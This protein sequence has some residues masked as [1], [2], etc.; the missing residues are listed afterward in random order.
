MPVVFGIALSQIRKQRKEMRRRGSHE[1]LGDQLLVDSLKN[2]KQ[3]SA[4]GLIRLMPLVI[5]GLNLE[6]DEF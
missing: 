5:W 6:D 2:I 1:K 4:L 3:E